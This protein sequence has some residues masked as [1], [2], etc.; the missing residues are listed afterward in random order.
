MR[1]EVL[2]KAKQTQGLSYREVGRRAGLHWTTVR[3][4]LVGAYAN[5]PLDTLRR[6]CRAL[7]VPMSEVLADELGE[8]PAAPRPGVPA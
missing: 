3:R 8:T 4:I 6:L 5:V 7:G 2:L 1:N